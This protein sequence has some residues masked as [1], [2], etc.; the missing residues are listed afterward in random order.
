MMGV[1]NLIIMCE[2]Q[3]KHEILQGYRP[4]MKRYTIKISIGQYPFARIAVFRPKQK[5]IT[6]IIIIGSF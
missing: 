2:S 5:K 6:K 1:N 3:H 4:M